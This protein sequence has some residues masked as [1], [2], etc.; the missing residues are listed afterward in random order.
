[1]QMLTSDSAYLID[2]GVSF[3]LRLG[4]ALPAHFLFELFGVQSLDAVDMRKVRTMLSRLS[5]LS[6]L[7]PYCDLYASVWY[8]TDRLWMLTFS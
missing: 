1:M 8:S 7:Q 6:S 5:V 2:N 3:F 4:R